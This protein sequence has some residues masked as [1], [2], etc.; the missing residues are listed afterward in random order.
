M[1][2]I[3]AL[4]TTSKFTS[5]SISKGEEILFEYNFTSHNRLSAAL[6]PSIKF[7]LKESGLKLNDIDVFGIA[8]GPGLFTGIRVGL[9]ALKGIIFP[10]GKPVVPVVVLQALAYKYIKMSEDMLIIPLIDAKRDE[11]YLAGYDISRHTLKEVISPCLVHINDV[12]GKLSAFHRDG[13]YFTG[14]G[15]EAHHKVITANF[16]RGSILCRSSFLAPEICKMTY[17]EYLS[18]NVI[19]DLQ[20]LMPFYIRKPDAEQNFPESEKKN[21]NKIKKSKNR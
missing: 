13:V 17:H 9:S 16:N 6:I 19:M 12:G 8:T 7:L 14:S 21:R 3:L 15:A 2:H 4:D 10:R 18:E 11:V 5:I 20:R 1:T